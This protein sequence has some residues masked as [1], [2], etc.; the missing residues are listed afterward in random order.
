MP[1][2]ALLIARFLAMARGLPVPKP[3]A[4]VFTLVVEVF[5]LPIFTEAKNAPL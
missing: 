1:N 3:A 4:L 2:T 5:C